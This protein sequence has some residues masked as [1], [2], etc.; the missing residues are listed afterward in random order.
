LYIPIEGAEETNISKMYF[1][2]NIKSLPTS[3]S[4]IFFLSLAGMTCTNPNS[5]S[6]V[7]VQKHITVGLI[8]PT[9]KLRLIPA[10]KIALHDLGLNASMVNVNLSET[11][12]ATKLDASTNF[13]P[14]FD[15]LL[16]HCNILLGDEDNPDDPA[17]RQQLLALEAWERTHADVPVVDPLACQRLMANRRRY[18]RP[19]CPRLARTL[20]HASPASHPR[21]RHLA[22]RHSDK[23]RRLAG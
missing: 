6:S 2:I 21:H 23:H 10:L 9:K 12:N 5:L 1:T 8:F 17:A 20:P 3:A 19:F 4:L 11:A 14:Y 16:S 13:L 22:F 18:V 7:K 15:I